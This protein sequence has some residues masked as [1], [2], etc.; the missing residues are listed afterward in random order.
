MH[1]NLENREALMAQFTPA[2]IEAAEKIERRGVRYGI[3]HNCQGNKRVLEELDKRNFVMPKNFTEINPQEQ[4]KILATLTTDWEKRFIKN[5]RW[6]PIQHSFNEIEFP[7]SSGHTF[8][9]VAVLCAEKEI[10]IMYPFR[11]KICLN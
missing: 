8:K 2:E 7:I 5:E 9:L 11:E 6:R 1:R 10:E 3:K 4:Q